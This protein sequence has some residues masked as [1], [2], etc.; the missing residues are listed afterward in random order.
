LSYQA[1]TT[2][3]RHTNNI[4]RNGHIDTGNSLLTK[5]AIRFAIIAHMTSEN[6]A[7]DNATNLVGIVLCAPQ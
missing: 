7:I 3:D 2:H 4:A 1:A 6:I 5:E